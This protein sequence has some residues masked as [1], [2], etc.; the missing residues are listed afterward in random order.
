MSFILPSPK[1]ASPS[2][3]K[4]AIEEDV[5]YVIIGKYTLGYMFP[6][7]ITTKPTN[8]IYIDVKTPEPIKEIDPS[9]NLNAVLGICKINTRDIIRCI[10]TSFVQEWYNKLIIDCFGLYGKCPEPIYSEEI[11]E[12]EESEEGEIRAPNKE[13]AVFKVYTKIK[14]YY[15][16]SGILCIESLKHEVHMSFVN[17]NYYAVFEFGCMK[18]PKKIM[19]VYD[20]KS[21]VLKIDFGN[22]DNISKKWKELYLNALKELKAYR[23]DKFIKFANYSKGLNIKS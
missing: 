4:Y 17:P 22:D 1:Y 10:D 21:V 8:E 23:Y 2:I 13:E 12:S 3:I 15:Q 11:E 19:K 9:R 5:M 6:Y 7:M 14:D 18:I 20:A 16:H